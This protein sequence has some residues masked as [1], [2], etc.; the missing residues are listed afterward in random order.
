M[1]DGTKNSELWLLRTYFGDDDD[2]AWTSLT[3]Q[4]RHARSSVSGAAL[5]ISSDR[6]QCQQRIRRVLTRLAT[7]A[8]ANDGLYVVIADK[9]TFARHDRTLLTIDCSA[10]PRD[11][12]RIP[13]TRM[14]PSR[15]FRLGIDRQTDT[16]HA[17]KP[18]R[19]PMPHTAPELLNF[20][21]TDLG[22]AGDLAANV[23]DAIRAS[24]GWRTAMT[25]DGSGG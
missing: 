18:N 7:R 22:D 16:A 24:L 20:E 25:R 17:S 2:A 19:L 23:G 11:A 9:Q 3:E 1:H 6:T 8:E 21:R 10:V 12:E 13:T 15:A 14:A 4:A 5:V